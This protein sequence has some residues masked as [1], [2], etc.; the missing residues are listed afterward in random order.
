MTL[1]QISYLA[2]IIGVILVVASLIYVGQ[3]LRQN[4]EMMR[5]ESRNMIQ[6]G[7]QQEILALMNNPDV[8]RAFSGESLDDESIRL[9]QW[10]VAALR[11]REHEWFQ[12]QN[13]A[14]DK[15]A[16]E[17]FSKSIPLILASERAQDW[18]NAA[19]P[20]FDDGFA[21]IVDELIGDAMMSAVHEKLASAIKGEGGAVKS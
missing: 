7:H 20:I 21:V 6:H 12:Y 14:L 18:W 11:S 4:T 5:A 3:Q 16:W 9:N 2:E 13:G 1:E 19:R 17:T 15:L 10:L 8:W